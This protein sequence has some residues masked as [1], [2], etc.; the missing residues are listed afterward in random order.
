[1]NICI[2]VNEYPPDKIAGTAVATQALARE[3][4]K[5]GFRVYV[6]V[7]ERKTTSRPLFR[8]SGAAVIRLSNSRIPVIR[9]ILR[10][11]KIRNI[12]G[13]LMPD[14]LHGQSISCGL[15][16]IVAGW[17]RSIP[18]VTSIQGY[19][20]Y[21]STPMQRM[22]EVRWS[23]KKANIVTAV[24]NDLATSCAAVIGRRD[25]GVIPHG[26]V[27]RGEIS[28]KRMIRKKFGVDEN[29]FILMCAARL[30]HSKGL[31]ILIHAMTYLQ[32]CTLWIAGDG[33]AHQELLELSVKLEV[34]RRVHFLGLIDYISV[35]QR[36]NAADAFV[37][38]SRTEP[39]G[40]CLLEAMDAG[41]PIIATRVGGIP[42]IVGDENGILV[43]PEDPEILASAINLL[44]YDP[45]QR[46]TMSKRNRNKAYAYRWE[47][48][49]EEYIAVY[50]KTLKME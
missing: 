4:I 5:N 29:E 9:W 13:R 39:F 27:H 47:N 50:R 16:G 3:L 48:L 32:K 45:F 44:M 37:L 19:D 49:I 42:E 22:T 28:D 18:V 35:V 36:M 21:E 33:N 17:F 7:T 14:V 38:P 20:F 12:V 41:L 31:D 46:A 30:H 40:I 15:Y 25:I 11:L 23:I 1:M 26:F 43:P 34:F 24:T 2:I 6:I 10:V 8:D